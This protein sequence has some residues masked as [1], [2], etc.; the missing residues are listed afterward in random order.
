MQQ[1]SRHAQSRFITL[2]MGS[3]A[4]VLVIFII[5]YP[6][7]AFQSSLQ[8]LTVW[9]KIVFPALLPFLIL[10]ELLIGFG[11]VQAL[12]TL[13]EPLMRLLFRI[14]G[15]G[16]WAVA[17][18]AVVGFPAGA[19]IT[20]SIIEKELLTAKEAERLVAISHLCSPI[21]LITVVGV[22]FLQNVK[23][24]LVL[25]V[26]HYLSAALTGWVM[27]IGSGFE[28][29]ENGSRSERSTS[30]VQGSLIRKFLD[31]MQES[32][33]QDGRAFGKLLGDAVSS[34]VQ[35]LML[36]G[37]YMMIFSVMLNVVKLALIPEVAYAVEASLSWLHL[38]SETL[39]HLV[40]GLFEIHLGT[41]D[42]SQAA[43][44]QP[45]WQIAVLSAFLGWGGLSAHAQVASITHRS[46]VR[47]LFFLTARLLHAA[48]AFTL[49]IVLWNPL[50][51]TISAATPAFLRIDPFT[52]QNV[53]PEAAKSAVPIARNFFE[54]MT[55]Q[56]LLLLFAMIAISLLLRFFHKRI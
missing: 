39:K 36:I 1:I 6:D 33:L 28:S 42:V 15:I 2:L 41:Y 55:G 16:G 10:S 25:A 9:W 13:L 8:G 32:Y 21:F 5:I 47:Y 35:T 54:P 38:G 52:V 34:S 17:A 7:G 26:V 30:K 37:G 50:T 14:P 3:M 53:S 44:A 11:V 23:L 29:I 4:A 48:F 18:G 46:P 40:S 24:G 45:M 51:R 56:L 20:A 22:G 27:S 12:G 31:T 43:G 49:T 19:R